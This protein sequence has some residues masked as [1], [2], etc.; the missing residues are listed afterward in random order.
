[1]IDALL[2]AGLIGPLEDVSD[3]SSVQSSPPTSRSPSPDFPEPARRAVRRSN[4]SDRLN[5]RMAEGIDNFLGFEIAQS[6]SWHLDNAR[7]CITAFKGRSEQVDESRLIVGPGTSP[8]EHLDLLQ[9]NGYNY[10]EV[11]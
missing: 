6:V 7:R 2:R 9:K 5:Q 1:M 3:F 10:V 8:K 11:K 4:K